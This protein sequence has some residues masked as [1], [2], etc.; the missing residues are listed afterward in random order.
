MKSSKI[1]SENIKL[2]E[3]EFNL[4]DLLDDM[5][6]MILPQIYDKSHELKIDVKDLNHEKVI[7]DSLRIQQIFVNLISNAIKYTEDGGIIKVSIKERPTRM[8][9]YGEYEI[10]FEDN[11]IGMSE[12]FQ[13]ILFDPFTRAEDHIMNGVTGT[14][15]GM[16][17]T[18]NLVHLMNGNIY[19]ESSLGEG[20]KFTVVIHLK[21]QQG[22]ERDLQQL[23]DL[24]VLVVD[25]DQD[26][27]ISTCEIL[28]GIG[29]QGEW[30]DTGQRAV[31]MVLDRRRRGEDFFAVILDWKMPGMD[32]IATAKEIRKQAGEDIPIIFLTAY[33]W[34]EIES[35]ARSVGVSKFLTKPLF[36]SRLIGSFLDILNPEEKEKGYQEESVQII[37]K[38]SK[39]KGVHLLLAEDNELNAEIAM[40]I[41]K[42]SGI[43]TDWAQ[44]GAEAVK[45]VRESA[46][47]YY[48]MVFMDIQ[49]PVMDGYKAAEE[50]RCL[51]RKDV[52]K[53]P[54][55]AMTANAFTEDVNRAKKAGMDD[56]IAKPID[57]VQLGGIM[58]RYLKENRNF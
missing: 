19:V 42:M 51:R 4:A 31:E 13:E 34:T 18:K 5:I 24:P 58:K 25:N 7:G 54:I 6:T 22:E 55:V 28:S 2:Q 57:F 43:E 53:L 9:Q 52:E 16:A 26:A 3:E 50:I 38:E 15:L 8:Q 45:M 21:I 27:C 35:E 10:C 23:Q 49:M 1:E 17:I 36:K 30:C 14:G 56:H 48:D 32:G 20:S 12:E 41:F 40:E 39:Y 33:D 47:N 29:I 37:E 46:E 11:G 44:N